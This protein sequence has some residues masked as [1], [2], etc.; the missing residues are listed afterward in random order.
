[1]LAEQARVLAGLVGG[2]GVDDGPMHR[3]GGRPHERIVE[4]SARCTRESARSH[5]DR[6]ARKPIADPPRGLGLLG[7]ILP[8]TNQ[9]SRR[10]GR[11]SDD[12]IGGLDGRDVCLFI[13]FVSKVRSLSNLRS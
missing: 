7:L 5:D 10:G 6:R 4:E 11:S 3:N 9:N 13:R 1:M 2:S 12:L 8:R